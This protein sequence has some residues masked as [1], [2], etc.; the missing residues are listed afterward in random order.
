M[1]QQ[2]FAEGAFELHN[3]TTRPLRGAAMLTMQG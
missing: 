3:K 2:T 1:R